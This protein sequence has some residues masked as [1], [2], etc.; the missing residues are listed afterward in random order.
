MKIIEKYTEKWALSFRQFAFDNFLYF[1][2]C[3]F[4]S[5]PVFH[6]LT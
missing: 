2:A 1:S 3:V 5:R 6:F 4:P